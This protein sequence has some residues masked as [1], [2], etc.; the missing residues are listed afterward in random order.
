[1]RRIGPLAK[2][3]GVLGV[4]VHRVE[5]EEV[6]EYK[7]YDRWSVSVFGEIG[8]CVKQ[9][10]GCIYVTKMYIHYSSVSIRTQIRI[11]CCL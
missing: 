11:P 6:K 8:V 9:N 2:V 5:R 10:M 3:F 7:S 1:M 4:G